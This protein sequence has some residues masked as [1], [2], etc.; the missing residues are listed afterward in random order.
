MLQLTE[1]LL[2]FLVI[3]KHDAINTYSYKDKLMDVPSYYLVHKII[4]VLI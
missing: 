4:L 1:F 2:V 3:L